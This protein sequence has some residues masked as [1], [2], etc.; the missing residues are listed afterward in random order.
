MDLRQEILV[1]QKRKQDVIQIDRKDVKKP[2]GPR[3]VD[4]VA[5]VIRCGPGIRPVG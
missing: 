1:A 5:G 2:A 4:G 3:R